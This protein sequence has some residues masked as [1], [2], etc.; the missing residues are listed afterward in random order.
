MTAANDEM[1]KRKTKTEA[2]EKITIYEF[3]THQTAYPMYWRN[4]YY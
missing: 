4:S 1:V 3:I 2:E